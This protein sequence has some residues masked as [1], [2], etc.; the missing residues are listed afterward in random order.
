MVFGLP[1]QN[2]LAHSGSEHV[3]DGIKAVQ[4]HDAAAA[5]WL[6]LAE[7]SAVGCIEE[8]HTARVRSGVAR[9]F[10]IRIPADDND[11]L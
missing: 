3:P 5:Y 1:Q 10:W 7:Q 9:Q 11:I 6:D 4:A 8:V 2:M